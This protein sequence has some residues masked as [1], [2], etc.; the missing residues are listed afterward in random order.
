VPYLRARTGGTR[1]HQGVLQLQLRLLLLLPLRM[2]GTLHLS[3]GL[4]LLLLLL[5]L[6]VGLVVLRAGLVNMRLPAL[7]FA[8]HGS[9]GGRVGS[10]GEQLLRPAGA[11][12]GPRAGRAP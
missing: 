2:R 8:N 1:R 5:L 6:G 9:H 7:L 11:G 10:A 12:A 3:M 4:L